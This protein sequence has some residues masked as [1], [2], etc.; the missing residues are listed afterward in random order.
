M[1]LGGA[2]SDLALMRVHAHVHQLMNGLNTCLQSCVP[3]TACHM[4]SCIA[5]SLASIAP[6]APKR[7]WLQRPCGPPQPESQAREEF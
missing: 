2:G 1:R 5:G 4:Q 3:P 6:H 7:R